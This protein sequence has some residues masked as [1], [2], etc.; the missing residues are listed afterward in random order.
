MQDVKQERS[1][2]HYRSCLGGHENPETEKEQLETFNEKYESLLD[3]VIKKNKDSPR[4]PSYPAVWVTGLARQS[5]I[6]R[7][8][9]P[10]RRSRL[11]SITPLELLVRI[12][13]L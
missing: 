2:R 3:F 9:L 7:I 6:R 4:R 12:T 11:V 1:L 8:T 5:S 10:T 13:H